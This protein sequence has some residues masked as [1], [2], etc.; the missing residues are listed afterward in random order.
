MRKS[1]VVIAAVAAAV[2][3]GVGA[4]V[5][6]KATASDRVEVTAYFADAQPLHS[7]DQVKAAGVPVG[8][9]DSIVLDHGVAKLDMSVDRTVLP[10][11]TDATARITQQDLLGERYVDVQRGSPT[12]P[13][14]P[15]PYVLQK[16]QTS[17]G[18]DLQEVLNSV[19]NPTGTALAAMLTTA[20]EGLQGQGTNAADAITA[21][22]PAMQ[23]TGELSSILGEQ[24]QVLSQLI[25]R[26]RPVAQSV[27]AGQGQKLDHL[28]DSTTGTLGAVSDREEQ[29]QNTLVQLPQT[30]ASAR[31]TLAH[32]SGVSDPTADS[33]AG[34]RPLTNDL[35]NVSGE[36]Q[37][38]SDAADPALAS[39]PAVLDRGNSLLDEAGPLVRSLQPAG[40]DLRS[41]GPDAKYLSDTATSAKLTNL[42][43]F[44]KGWSMAT[45]DYDATSHYFKAIVV[46]TPKAIGGSAAGGL[47]PGGSKPLIP[48]LPLPGGPGATPGPPPYGT[49]A[50][51]TSSDPGGSAPAGQAPTD[52]NTGA[53]S[54]P[55]GTKQSASGPSAT[56]LRPAQEGAM[57][58]QMLGGS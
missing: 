53:N 17:R 28:V 42:M 26:A 12:A 38:F 5:A 4:A 25:D 2:V 21:L 16:Q 8:T 44:V 54:A 55:D 57:L 14:L 24:N 58:D 48:S 13:A 49:P 19:D 31:R 46:A 6:L 32:L 50:P 39:L 47:L 45:S 56:G 34:L 43:E 20:G 36:L 40:P 7:G 15:Q 22:K 18:T 1:R 29:V 37:R 30:I 27:A 35:D 11:H 9:I 10:L 3:F 33:L 51:G 41:I 52:N 23:Q